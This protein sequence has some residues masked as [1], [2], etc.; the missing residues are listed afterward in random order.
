MHISEETLQLLRNFNE[1]NPSLHFK[2]GNELFTNSI[3]QTTVA[4][5]EIKEEFD[6]DFVIFDLQQF[7]EVIKLF[8]TPEFDF[9][10][11]RY[12]EVKQPNKKRSVKYTYSPIGCL[13]NV[14]PGPPNIDDSSIK[15]K[16]NLTADTLNGVIK[17]ASVL[18][19][20]DISVES[21]DDLVMIVISDKASSSSNKYKVVVGENT[22][23]AEFQIFFKIANWKLLPFD[24]KAEIAVK[25]IGGKKERG[26][27][28][29]TCLGDIY[30]KLIYYVPMEKSCSFYNE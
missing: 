6:K 18:K 19:A 29:F 4:V 26:I 24:Y 22:S 15:V 30:D 23:G 12:V 28:R 13:K 21:E 2:E 8:E 5:A 10:D 25:D 11:D 20:E 9:D 3:S 17:A 7:L 27:V 14:L 16:F 1:I